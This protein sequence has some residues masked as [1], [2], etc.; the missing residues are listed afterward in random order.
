[1]RFFFG[2]LCVLMTFSLKAQ[3]T[4]DCSV[5]YNTADTLVKLILEDGISYSNASLN[6]LD[7]AAGYFSGNS[8]IGFNNGVVMAT[9]SVEN[10][11]PDAANSFGG[12]SSTDTDLETLLVSLNS[13]TTNISDLK[14]LEFDFIPISDTI[15]FEYVFASDEYG[16]YTCSPYNDV[17]GVFLSGPGING[18]YT[19]DA[20]NIALVPDPNNLGEYTDTPVSINTINSGTS[21]Y[22]FDGCENID[23]NWQD[24]SVYFVDNSDVTTVSLHGFTVPLIARSEVV[25]N[26]SYHMKIAIA[27]VGDGAVNSAIFIK[28][29]GVSSIID[30]C[31]DPI[32]ENY[33][34][35]ANTDDASCVYILGCTDEMALNYTGNATLDD[36]SCE[37]IEIDTDCSAPYNTADA[38]VELIIGD[39]VSYSNASINTLDCAAGYFSET[40]NI[41]IDNGLVMATGGIGSFIP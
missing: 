12:I 25:P 11:E 21:S 16:N 14:I 37:F 26:E 18:P 9:G 17:F 4:T 28:E 20:I 39:G 1:M 38:L 2:L 10:I 7:C 6:T 29:R 34:E 3:I 36:G 8:N 15:I 35:Y 40:S 41:G 22:G 24:Y 19:N 13:A 23:P 32:A 27:D 5:P 31:T 30:G 33:D